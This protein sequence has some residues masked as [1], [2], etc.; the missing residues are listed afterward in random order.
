MPFE[1]VG[2]GDGLGVEGWVRCVGGGGTEF[3]CFAEEAANRWGW[4]HFVVWMGEGGYARG[5]VLA[6]W[7]GFL[8]LDDMRAVCSGSM[9]CQRK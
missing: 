6:V 1:E 3:E 9:S 4:R 5:D 2:I 7:R 8:R